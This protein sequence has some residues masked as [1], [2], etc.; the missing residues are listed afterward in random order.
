MTDLA[1]VLASL[2]EA[3]PSPAL[4]LA[5]ARGLV[6]DYWTDL[7]ARVRRVEPDTSR[8]LAALERA[9][10]ADAELD[11]EVRRR[12]PRPVISSDAWVLDLAVS[13]ASVDDAVD[14]TGRG[15]ARGDGWRARANEVRRAKRAA[16]RLARGVAR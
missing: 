12:G 6:S 10:D 7:D 15:A 1:A 11:T 8:R 3:R 13:V 4:D 9:N 2:V 16:E 5:R 14:E